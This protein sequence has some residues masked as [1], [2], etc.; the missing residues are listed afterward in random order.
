MASEAKDMIVKP[1]RNAIQSICNPPVPGRQVADP[2]P[3]TASKACRSRM[4]EMLEFG[5]LH[6]ALRIGVSVLADPMIS[7]RNCC[8]DKWL[9][10]VPVNESFRPDKRRDI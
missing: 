6:P 8:D 7:I 10:P 9:T 4:T 2:H 1:I 5:R 3:S